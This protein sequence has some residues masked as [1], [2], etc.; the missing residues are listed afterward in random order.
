M[1]RQYLPRCYDTKAF[2]VVSSASVGIDQG[3]TLGQ[4]T[5]EGMS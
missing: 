3:R 2:A 4:E 1:L 5:K